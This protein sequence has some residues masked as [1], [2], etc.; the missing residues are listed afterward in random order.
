YK[1]GQHFDIGFDYKAGC[2]IDLWMDK[3]YLAF[4]SAE[5]DTTVLYAVLGQTIHT[6]GN[7]ARSKDTTMPQEASNATKT[8]G[9]RS[10][11]ER[12][13]KCRNAAALPGRRRNTKLPLYAPDVAAI[14][15]CHNIDGTLPQKEVAT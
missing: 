11:V 9:H 12:K 3:H 5:R 1:S 8:R 14:W 2:S 4:Q 15:D 7:V 13:D 6:P 10:T